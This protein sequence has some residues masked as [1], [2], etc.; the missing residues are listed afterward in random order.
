MNQ[1]R[2]RMLIACIKVRFH[3]SLESGDIII[4]SFPSRVFVH[5]GVGLPEFIH[6]ARSTTPLKF[7]Y[8]RWRDCA[9]F[10]TFTATVTVNI[11][12]PLTMTLLILLS[13]YYRGITACILA[14]LL[15]GVTQTPDGP[16]KRP[17]PG[18]FSSH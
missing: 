3:R 6:R 13:L 1:L 9:R 16:F 8:G 17:H 7:F 18:K 10:L 2:Q 5:D 11:F 12:W 14:F 4:S 15:L